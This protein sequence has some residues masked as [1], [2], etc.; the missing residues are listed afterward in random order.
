MDVKEVIKQIH[1][2]ELDDLHAISRAVR[3]ECDNI[4]EFRRKKCNHPAEHRGLV[5]LERPGNIAEG[6]TYCI[7]NLEAASPMETLTTTTYE[8]EGY[9]T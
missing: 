9:V 5:M 6:C 2:L 4:I 3:D 8:E 7:T 1:S